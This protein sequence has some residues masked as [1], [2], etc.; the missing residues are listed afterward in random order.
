MQFIVWPPAKWLSLGTESWTWR[1]WGMVLDALEGQAV[2]GTG[3][4][5][6]FVS[7][8]K[9]LAAPLLLLPPCCQNLGG[10]SC[11]HGDFQRK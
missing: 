5:H 3:G 2:S 10:V 6:S 1:H 7:Q 4:S 9:A 11:W 8:G